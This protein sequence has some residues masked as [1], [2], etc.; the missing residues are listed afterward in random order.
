VTIAI[1]FYQ[2]SF[3]RGFPA[4]VGVAGGCPR[5]PAAREAT[6]PIL[7]RNRTC[8]REGDAAAV[9]GAVRDRSGV[10]PRCSCKAP[11]E[12]PPRRRGE[13]ELPL[14]GSNGTMLDPAPAAGDRNAGR[15][16]GIIPVGR[17]SIPRSGFCRRLRLSAARDRLVGLSNHAAGRARL[18][19]RQR[20]TR[21]EH[22]DNKER[23]GCCAH[24]FPS[25]LIVGSHRFRRRLV[26]R[27]ESLGA[28]SANR[29]NDAA[30]FVALP[31]AGQR[32]V[33]GF[34][35]IRPRHDGP[36]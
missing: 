14:P 33:F 8:P 3:P 11:V 6:S 22:D 12:M 5:H 31:T 10:V 4:A 20:S 28:V 26:R 15:L 27:A 9:A 1:A 19:K 23:S 17:S 16:V 36:I 21:K 7:G 34:L 25:T 24:P 2:P 29:C 18:S 30:R 35:N 32:V 13:I